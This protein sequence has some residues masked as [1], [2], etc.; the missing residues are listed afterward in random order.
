M[1]Y[2]LMYRAVASGGAGGGRPVNPISTRGA[3][4][5]H[6]VLRAPPPEFINLAT[7]LMYYTAVAG[8][9]PVETR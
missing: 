9:G 3:H 2:I 7:A 1:N 6:P 4:F 8:V 5:P